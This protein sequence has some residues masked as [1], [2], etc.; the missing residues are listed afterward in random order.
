MP[1]QTITT[2]ERLTG[3]IAA[4][5]LRHIA[6]ATAN[7]AE[8]LDAMEQVAPAAAAFTRDTIEMIRLDLAALHITEP[9]PCSCRDGE[10]A[11]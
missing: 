10:D 7:F 11:W 2:A 1:Q 5:I 9:P 4:D 6:Q 3:P 8:M